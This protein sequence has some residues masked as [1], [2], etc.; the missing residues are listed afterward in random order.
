MSKMQL[1][2]ANTVAAS[3]GSQS[4]R[5]VA[6]LNEKP[7]H[8]ALK[9]WY[10][11]PGDRLESCV[12]GFVVD[13]VRGD[14]LIEIQTGNFPAIKRKLT[15]LAARHPVRLVYPIA[16]DK[17]I[18]KLAEGGHGQA[19]RR[20]SPKR[21]A[22]EH[23]FEELVSFPR[24]L[25]NPSF[26]IELLLVQEEEIRR[27]DAIRG[28]RRNG[29]VTQE[30][31]LL[32]VVGRQLFKGPED[33]HSVLPSTLPDPFT[34]TDLAHALARPRRLAQKIVYCLRLIGCITQIGKT[35][36]SILYSRVATG[37]GSPEFLK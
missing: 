34:T 29:W 12:D 24:L 7:L 19:S 25:L 8:A 26:S 1:P 14:L 10:A 21:G 3:R 16:Q 18:V 6:V 27:H 20:R 5:R 33:L 22:F 30:R 36:G 13:I 11:Q 37:P 17:W 32:R 23:L 4:A 35:G 31:R 9:T 2:D 15:K 28:W